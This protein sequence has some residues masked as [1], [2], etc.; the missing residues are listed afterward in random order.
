MSD[1]SNEYYADFEESD[2][3]V[4]LLVPWAVYHYDNGGK[5]V[6][7]LFREERGHRLSADLSAWLDAQDRAWL[8]VWEVQRVEEGTG[9]GVKDLLTHEERFVHEVKGSK[10]LKPRDCVLGR[11]VEQGGV[12]TFCGTHPRY[13]PPG[14]ADHVVRAGRRICGVRTRA[15][16]REKLRDVEVLHEL[17]DFW[18]LRIEEMDKPMPFPQLANTDGDPLLMTTDHFEFDAANRMAIV[19]QLQ[20]LE[21]AQEALDEDGE[22]EVT[23]TRLGNA[24]IKAWDNTIVGR[25]LV[26]GSRLK[27]ETNSV[28]RADTLRTRVEAGLGALLRHRVRDHAD[29][30]SMLKSAKDRPPAREEEQPPEVKAV[31]R[32][33][34][35][36]HMAQWLDDEIPALDG[37]TPRQAK[38]K[39]GSQRKLDLLL[40]D[41]E[42]REAR[43]PKEERYDYGRIRKELGLDP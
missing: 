20:E 10:V 16:A 35:E 26:G 5:T 21:G 18:H 39:P 6:A 25:V 36:K 41:M 4:Q 11:V 1:V 40:R 14:E 15:V 42:N 17:I 9:V 12:S 23:F 22:A 31:L 7:Q 32:D 24:K 28:K 8:S 2:Y 30:E 43:L 13:L 37:L 38:K 19:A 3:E 33:F 34:K 27:I 29:M